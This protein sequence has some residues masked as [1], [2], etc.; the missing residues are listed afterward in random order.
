MVTME[1]GVKKTEFFGRS[2]VPENQCQGPGS[3][4]THNSQSKKGFSCCYT[5]NCTPPAPV[6]SPN[7]TRQN[8]LT[9]PTCTGNGVDWCDTGMTMRCTGPETMC[10]LQYSNMS[11]GSS[12]RGSSS[13]SDKPPPSGNLPMRRRQVP[14]DSSQDGPP[15][16]CKCAALGSSA[17]TD[18]PPTAS[19]A[20]D[21]LAVGGPSVYLGSG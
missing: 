12:P 19:T 11:A 6:L 13:S 21:V 10:I 2:C 1:D 16:H 9:C 5:D 18:E 14:S 3:F 17:R 8:G 7:S 20:C 15:L 4:S